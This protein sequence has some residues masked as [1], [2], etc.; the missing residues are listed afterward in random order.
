M[1][2]VRQCTS[3][4]H[5]GSGFYRFHLIDVPENLEAVGISWPV[6]SHAIWNLTT[7]RGSC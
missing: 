6:S 1:T 2:I 5:T 7:K 4:E 3:L